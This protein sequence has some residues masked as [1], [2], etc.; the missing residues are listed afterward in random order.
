MPEELQNGDIMKH[1]TLMPS[2]GMKDFLTP[3]CSLCSVP[4]QVGN[5]PGQLAPS[6]LVLSE[7]M[8]QNGSE[9][10]TR[11]NTLSAQS[12]SADNASPLGSAQEPM[13]PAAAETDVSHAFFPLQML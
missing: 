8:V 5:V 10:S 4:L 12:V 1:S 6:L 13:T 9:T 2:R 11:L 3:V 7:L